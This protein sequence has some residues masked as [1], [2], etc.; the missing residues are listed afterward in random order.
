MLFQ[1]HFNWNPKNQI[2]SE[3]YSKHLIS[4]DTKIIFFLLPFLFTSVRW[5]NMIYK[6]LAGAKLG[7]NGG[8]RIEKY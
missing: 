4:K 6:N 8:R 7:G 1:S 3:Y 5:G 2:K